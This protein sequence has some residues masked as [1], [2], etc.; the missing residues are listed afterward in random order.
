MREHN[1]VVVPGS[2]RINKFFRKVQR[3][4]CSK[5]DT[6]VEYDE[7]LTQHEVNNFVALTKKLLCLPPVGTG[8][9]N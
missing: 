8:G 4:H 7:R 6:T 3:W 5:C 2:Q 1:F 9:G